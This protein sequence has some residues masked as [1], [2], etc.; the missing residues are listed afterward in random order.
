MPLYFESDGS[1]ETTQ[2]FLKRC[3]QGPVTPAVLR[4]AEA[5]VQAL[6]A[7]TPQDSGITASSWSYE[8][9]DDA[10]V[11]T[12]W[13]TNSNVVD[14]FN[15]AVGLQYGHGTNNGGWVAGTDYINPVLEPIFDK[16][17]DAAWKE[18]NRA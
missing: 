4:M 17:A 2:S 9:V 5:G 13:F 16:M 14:G 3:V 8:V 10:G 15:V 18:V 6:K 12:I 11:Q 7:N 1:F